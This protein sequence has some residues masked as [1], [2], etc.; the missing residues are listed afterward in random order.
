MLDRAYSLLEVKSINDELREICGIATH[1]S[2]DRENDCVVAEGIQVAPEIPLLLRHKSDQ[3]VG[4]A[5]LGRPTKD[6]VPFTATMPKIVEPGAVRDL[7]ESAWTLVKYGLTRGCSIGFR[8]L[9]SELMPSGGIRFLKTEI[10]ELSLVEIPAHQSA[11]ILTVRDY[12]H[13]APSTPA[14]IQVKQPAPVDDAPMSHDRADRR[15]RAGQHVSRRAGDVSGGLIVGAN[16][17]DNE[18]DAL[19]VRLRES[20]DFAT[21][22]LVMDLLDMIEAYA[23]KTDARIAFLENAQPIYETPHPQVPALLIPAPPVPEKPT[24]QVI[25]EIVRD[26]DGRVS[27]VVATPI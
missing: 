14:T 5:R 1:P 2:P 21:V 20:D 24:P 15:I 17:T 10:L 4:R 27:N 26:P 8:V 11:T 25:F 3:P 6:G 16:T 9:E 19:Q 23:K 12:D 18:L 7:C 22:S 13:A